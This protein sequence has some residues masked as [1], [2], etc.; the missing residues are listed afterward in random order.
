MPPG[1]R[2][3][4][5]QLQFDG[6]AGEAGTQLVA[7][8]EV[9]RHPAAPH[10][11]PNQSCELHKGC[12]SSGATHAYWAPFQGQERRTLVARCPDHS[13]GANVRGLVAIQTVRIP[14]Q[15]STMAGQ[16][17][18]LLSEVSI[19]DL[20]KGKV[21]VDLL[22]EIEAVTK[23]VFEQHPTFE[24]DRLV[25]G[26]EN[27]ERVLKAALQ[28]EWTGIKEYSEEWFKVYRA[29]SRRQQMAR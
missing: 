1:Q 9:G 10:C 24:S 18:N 21:R 17:S 27:V 12:Q 26:A 25:L 28:Q 16:F 14:G 2:K 6:Q 22:K 23:D 11:T 7:V 8:M 3:K 29:A 19:A 15:R 20:L 5:L 13:Y 4:A